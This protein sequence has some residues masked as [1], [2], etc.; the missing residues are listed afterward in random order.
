MMKIAF[1][2]ADVIRVRVHCRQFH[3]RQVTPASS[4]QIT[5]PGFGCSTT[6]SPCAAVSKSSS[7]AARTSRAGP[8]Y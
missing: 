1:V 5:S 8:W 3:W 7:P 2:V 6:G 4:R